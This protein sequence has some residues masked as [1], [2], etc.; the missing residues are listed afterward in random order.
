MESF[1]N[2]IKDY[3]HIIYFLLFVYCA[4]KSGWLPLFAGYAAYSDAL[5]LPMVL[6]ACLFGG[7][8]GD[9]IRFFVARKYGIKWLQH[10]NFIG[11]LFTRARELS[12]RYGV[13]YMYVYRYPKGLRTIGALPVGLSDISWLKFTLLNASSA[14]LWVVLL[15]GGGYFFGST[16]DAFAVQTLTSISVL[17]L[18]IFFITLYRLWRTDKQMISSDIKSVPVFKHDKH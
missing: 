13:I 11:K 14:L 6:L 16:M 2:Q 12:H 3:G 7:Y 8:L 5:H 1:L 4:I 9:E 17:M 10:D 18:C 15:V